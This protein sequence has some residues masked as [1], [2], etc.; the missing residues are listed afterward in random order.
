MRKII[1]IFL[2]LL[3]ILSGCK[4]EDPFTPFLSQTRELLELDEEVD[5]LTLI[6]DVENAGLKFEVTDSNLNTAIPGEY[7]VTY[8]I[9]SADGKKSIE[10]TYVFTVKDNDAP[11]LTVDD[12]INISQGGTFI[13]SNYASAM[14]GRDGDVSNMI[15]YE[16]VVNAFVAGTYKITVSV[17]DRF[18]N[19]ATKEVKVVVKKA[20]EDSYMKEIAGNYTDVTYTQGQAPTLTINIDGSFTLFINGC[21]MLNSVEGKYIMVENVLYLTSEAHPFSEID[22]ENVITFEVQLDGSIKFTSEINAC[23]PIYGD[24]F[25]KR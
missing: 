24:V 15:T 20:S 22:E 7:N 21:S 25:L 16:G 8:K 10:K 11:V 14:D 5:V 12:T 17:K 19:T 13:I 18:G 2:C 1:L 23:A 4:K 3:F 9:S 6:K